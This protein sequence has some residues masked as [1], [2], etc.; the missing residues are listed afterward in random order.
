M[1]WVHRRSRCTKSQ[2]IID[3]C[4]AHLQVG[5]VGM[6]PLIQFVHDDYSRGI[7]TD[8]LGGPSN[9]AVM[10]R[11]MGRALKAQW[12]ASVIYPLVIG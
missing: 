8:L 9:W 5:I 4:A 1:L 2:S 6:T 10:W 11:K 12:V 3:P 7:R